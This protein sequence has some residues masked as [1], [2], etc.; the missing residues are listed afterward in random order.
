MCGTVPHPQMFR[1]VIA[2]LL[3][4]RAMKNPNSPIPLGRRDF[5]RI[6]A[7]GAVGAGFLLHSTPAVARVRGANERV[8][9]GVI[10][11]GRQGISNMRN[12]MRHADAEV[13][14]I[15]DVY[16]PNLALGAEAAPGAERYV[17]FRHLLDR[18]DID[19][20]MINT[21]DHWHALQTVMA[22]QAGKDVYVEK[23]ISVAVQEGRR[24][25][26]AARRYDRVVQVGTQQRSGRHFQQAADVVRSGVLGTISQVRTWNFGNETPAGI[27]NPPDGTPPADLDWDLWLGPAPMRPFNPNRFGVFPNRWATFRWFWDYA[28]GMMT[29]WGV[30]WLDTVHQVMGVDAPEFVSAS[31]GKFAL[32]DNRETPDTIL[33]TFQ[34]PGFICTYENRVA[35]AAPISGKSNGVLIHGTEGTLFLDRQGFE[36][37]PETRRVGETDVN[38]MEGMQVENSNQHHLDHIHNFV[39]CVK[40]RATPIC[41]IEIGQRSTTAALLGNIAYRT[42]RRIQW[43]AR[44]ERIVGDR[45]ASRQLV[46]GYRR[47]WRL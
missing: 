14:A 26:E 23:P 19:A 7:A 4:T 34:Y 3:S 35:N 30:H 46:R 1:A 33:A 42:G 22:C 29:D 40:S 45:D 21:P 25:V 6:G 13:V 28:G 31:G 39:D 27:G 32:E 37:I 16:G 43:D 41:D 44:T 47:P 18:Q 24:M 15:C 8:R 12:A 10:G 9:I 17:D 38:R 20:V 2:H 5:I 36:I 11:T